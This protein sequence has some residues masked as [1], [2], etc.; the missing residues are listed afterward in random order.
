MNTLRKLKHVAWLI[1]LLT[2]LYP[3]RGA[4]DD[5]DIFVGT[6]A[7]KQDNPNVLIVLD[8]QSNWSRND[9]QFPNVSTVGGMELGAIQSVINSSYVNQNTNVGILEFVPSGSKNTP[10][11]VGGYARFGIKAMDATG[12]ASLN[13]LL[14]FMQGNVTSPSEKQSSGV[15][16]G[17]LVYDAYNYFA[18]ANAWASPANIPTGYADPTAYT[19]ATYTKFKSPLSCGTSCAKNFIILIG[20]PLSS[21]PPSDDA[22]N[23]GALTSVG[24]N[25]SQLGKHMQYSYSVAGATTPTSLGNSTQCYASQT[26]CN[27]ALATASGIDYIALGCGNHASCSCGAAPVANTTTTCPAGQ[28]TYTVTGT[29]NATPIQTLNYAMTGTSQGTGRNNNVF[30]ITTSPAPGFA[31]GSTVSITGCSGSGSQTLTGSHTVTSVSGS[32]FVISDGNQNAPACAGGNVAYTK[33]GTPQTT[34]NLGQTPSCYA[35]AASCTT[36]AAASCSSQYT[37]GCACGTPTASTYTTCAATGGNMF[38]VNAVDTSYG[39][40]TPLD[41][42]QLDVAPDNADEWSRFLYQKGIP[43]PNCKNPDGTALPMSQSV[44]TYTIDTFNAKPSQP[45]TGLLSSMAAVGGGKYFNAS[46]AN[47]LTQALQ[48]IFMEIQSVNSTFAS[49]SLPINATNRSQNANQVFIGMFRPDPNANPRWFGNVKRYQLILDSGGNVQL[50]DVNGAVAVNN[51]TGFLQDCATSWWTSDSPNPPNPAVGWPANSGYWSAYSISPN[52]ASGCG[53]A[54]INVYSDLPD[55]SRV[56]KGAVAEVLRKG[57]NPAVT[58]ATPTWQVNRTI[59]TASGTT[60]QPFNAANTGLNTVVNTA[61]QTTADWV[62]GNDT[63]DENSN[64]V[65]NETRASLHGDVVHSR[66]LPVNYCTTATCSNVVVYYGANDGTLRAVNADSGQEYWAFVPPEVNSKLDRLRAQTPLVCYPNDPTY[67]IL[68][69]TCSSP[70]VKRDYFVDGSIG[71]YQTATNDKVWIYPTMRRGGRMIYAFDVTNANS[72]SIK[73]KFG[74]PNLADDLNCVGGAGVTSIG[75]TWSIPNVGFI[76]GYSTTAPIMVVGGGYDTCEDANTTSPSCASEK[77]RVA[78]VLDA[79]NGALLASFATAGAAISD[80]AMID[81]D[82]DGFVDYAYFGDT[83]GNLYRINFSSY[84]SSS[85]LYSP[86]TSGGWTITR[87]AY[88]AGSGRKF[89]FAPALFGGKG[90]V[91]VTLGSGDRE[92]PLQSQYPYTTPVLNRFY[93]YRDCLSSPAPTASNIAGGDNLDDSTIMNGTSAT[94]SVA[95][96]AP[97]TLANNCAANKGWYIDL[98]NGAG[99]QTV[100]SAVISGGM[101]TFSTNRPIPAAAG[102]CSTSLGEAR[103]YWLSLYSGSGAIGVSGSCGG[104]TSAKFAGGGLP[105]SPVMGTVP[106]N[107]VP[108]TVVIGAVN[109]SGAVSSPISPQKATATNLPARKRVYN[110]IKGDN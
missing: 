68:T 94:G 44:T 3:L 14:N 32:T 11:G 92:H 103:G 70:A 77:G 7:G 66:P 73:W 76:K 79:A 93:V 43:I 90:K 62:V 65:T 15:P 82:L 91:Y 47:S 49:A 52:P 16:Y 99:E 87:V 38:P 102:T 2:M 108:T 81:M 109:K 75:Q 107:G 1:S 53:T 5:I 57:N 101:V 6:S 72:P 31:A 19:D 29:T 21:G 56:E 9:Q 64:G 17:S 45:F 104:S 37:G 67:N 106:I 63:Q 105:P 110:F 86:L 30:T 23:T 28:L 71:I 96:N 33:P 48:Q 55:G 20:N 58:N 60:L 88:T 97:Q 39:T 12:K 4:A 51:N 27:T 84:D 69:G 61:N 98:N 41:A 59:Y 89:E 83:R 26:A 36:A 80:I 10:G 22:T 85:G 13:T 74:C 50:G 8:N 95:C 24:G 25:A 78:Y 54:G 34:T 46:D 18:G 100:T 42:L 35:D 40:P